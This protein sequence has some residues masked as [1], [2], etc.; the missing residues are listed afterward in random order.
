MWN[1]FITFS[2]ML[3]WTWPFALRLAVLECWCGIM[4]LSR[5]RCRRWCGVPRLLTSSYRGGAGWGQR[6]FKLHIW[7]VSDA[8]PGCVGQQMR[9]D[10][11]CCA[12]FLWF[13]GF[14]SV[15][16]Q[17]GFWQSVCEKCR[18]PSDWVAAGSVHTVLSS[19]FCCGHEKTLLHQCKNL[20][21]AITQR[22]S[23]VSTWK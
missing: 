21:C 19:W 8:A 22:C 4:L 15:L 7:G 1:G 5:L 6:G 3:V 10:W 11:F 13:A 9:W 12:G 17:S 14:A 2:G 16:Q 18:V 20:I 23:T